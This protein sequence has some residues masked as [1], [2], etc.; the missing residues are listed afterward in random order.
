MNIWSSSANNELEQLT[1]E[2]LNGSISQEQWNRLND[3]IVSDQNAC[4]YYTAMMA[5]HSKLSRIYHPAQTGEPAFTVTTKPQIAS[6]HAIHLVT[7]GSK[8]HKLFSNGWLAP[9][10]VAMGILVFFGFYTAINRT[11]IGQEFVMTPETGLGNPIGWFQVV[12]EHREGEL[13]KSPGNSRIPLHDG[14]IIKLPLH[15]AQVVFDSGVAI[16]VTGPTTLELHEQHCLLTEGKVRV[17]VSPGA[18]GFQI[19][20][21][22]SLVTDYG[23]EFGVSVDQTGEEKVAVFEGEVGINTEESNGEILMSIGQGVTVNKNGELNRLYVVD[24]HTFDYQEFSKHPPLITSVLDNVRSDELYDFYRIIRNGIQED[25]RI[26]VDR[27]HEFNSVENSTLPEYL[28]DSELVMTYNDDKIDDMYE[29]TLTLDRPAELYVLFDRRLQP[30]GWLSGQ[31]EKLPELIGVD[32]E[33][34]LAHGYQRLGKGGGQSIDNR[35]TIWK[36]RV[37]AGDFRLGNNGSSQSLEK[38]MYVVVA[39]D[40]RGSMD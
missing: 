7:P 35:F 39:K 29:M 17:R 16:Q 11:D 15:S 19:H 20:T 38:L 10:V 6:Q 34:V 40:V 1:N 18:E 28:N 37:D 4:D 8:R 30:P 3:M 31:F 13:H 22:K 36:T 5:I 12:A 25:S 23:T 26:Y 14:Q 33:T 32:E 2:A 21:P 9:F 27:V 24:D